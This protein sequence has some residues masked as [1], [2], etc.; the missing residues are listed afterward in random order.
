[1]P[2]AR[3]L[4]RPR[5]VA[6]FVPGRCRLE[7]SPTSWR[8]GMRMLDCPGESRMRENFMS[9]LG[10]GCWKR[11]AG[12]GHRRCAPTGNPGDERRV[13]SRVASP[14]QRSTSLG[15]SRRERVLTVDDELCLGVELAA[16]ICAEVVTGDVGP[17]GQD[18]DDK[19][20][21]TEQQREREA[22]EGAA[23]PPERWTA[24]Q[25]QRALDGAPE[26]RQRTSPSNSPGLADGDLSAGRGET[27]PVV[28]RSIGG[29]RPHS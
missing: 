12:Y 22:P 20:E 25:G 1:V 29:A 28:H 16:E 4:T 19:W 7:R 15:V 5:L 10:R 21:Q 2:G 23:N 8:Y 3:L 18:E 27:A 6:M 26:P 11:N 9:G 13:C 24:T 17:R 14:R